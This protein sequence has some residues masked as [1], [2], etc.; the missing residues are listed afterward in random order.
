M[1]QQQTSFRFG[2]RGPEC[3]EF[4][5]LERSRSEK[6]KLRH[7]TA[8]R[9]GGHLT[10]RRKGDKLMQTKLRTLAFVVVASL[11]WISPTSAESQWAKAKSFRVKYIGT[12]SWYGEQHQGLKMANGKRFDR[13]KLTAAS[14]Y[15]PLGTTIRVVNVKNGESVVVTI[16]DRGPNLRLNRILDLSEAAA[17][18]LNYRKE[19]L[20]SVFLYPVTQFE[21]QS[22]RFDSALIWPPV[23]RPAGVL[24]AEVL[25][26]PN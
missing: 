7:T 15:F 21:T 19:G 5:V 25:V 20:T 4:E 12:A 11:L 6:G 1:F 8:I 10:D 14:W 2:A 13:H 23:R 22:A 18:R 17:I 3:D 24:E 26:T 9:P 16:T